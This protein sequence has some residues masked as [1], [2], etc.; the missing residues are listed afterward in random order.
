MIRR[1]PRSTLFPYTTL[2]RSA[3]KAFRMK[4][5]VERLGA[6]PA[7]VARVVEETD[8]QRDQY[9]KTYYGRH[10]HE[11]TNYD[12]VVNAEKLGFEGAAGL[13]VTQARGRGW[14]ENGTRKRGRGTATPPPSPVRG[15]TSPVG[16]PPLPHPP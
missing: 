13:I 3:S 4:L 16:R 7:H 5:A 9:V 8:R 10:R 12:L 6:A 14:G 15:P 11:V 2:F 1:P